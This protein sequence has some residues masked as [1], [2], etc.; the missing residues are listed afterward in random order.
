[1]MRPAGDVSPVYGFGWKLDPGAGVVWH[2][3]SA[4]VSS[5]SR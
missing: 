3:G 1:M 2:D 4:P 5:P